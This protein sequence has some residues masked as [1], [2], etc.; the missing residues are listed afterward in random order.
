MSPSSI[1]DQKMGEFD[2]TLGVLSMFFWQRLTGHPRTQSALGGD[3][4]TT[5]DS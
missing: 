5:G 3:A 2:F 1:F 4:R